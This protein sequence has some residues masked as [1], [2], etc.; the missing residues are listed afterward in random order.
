MRNDPRLA[1]NSGFRPRYCVSTATLV[2]PRI[3]LSVN[4]T[5]MRLL[6]GS[7]G[8]VPLAFTKM[9]KV[10]VALL[11]SVVVTVAEGVCKQ[12]PASGWSDTA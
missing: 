11:A 1:L 12:T 3:V 4:V 5:K 6:A 2:S 7:K 10:G 8:I 9:P